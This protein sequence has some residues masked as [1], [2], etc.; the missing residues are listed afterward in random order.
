MTALPCD[1]DAARLLPW[2]VT[3]TLEAEEA[4]RVEAH[5]GSCATCRADL[6]H[7][8]RLHAALLEDAPRQGA[9]SAAAG[10]QKLM[11]RIGET[12]Q[13][14]PRRSADV[15]LRAATTSGGT[16]PRWIIAAV[17]AQALALVLVGIE[18]QRKSDGLADA[19]YRTLTSNSASSA[20]GTA[21]LRVVF[22]PGTTTRELAGILDTIGARIVD[23]PSSAGAYALAL[24]TATPDE[25]TLAAHLATLRADARVIF[26]E[27]IRAEPAR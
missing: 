4:A 13:A 22:A 24:S 16:V 3:G 11:A 17:V 15:P 7:E 5:L 18:L 27:P 26:A 2:Y 6:E 10:F 14:A 1:S 23:G 25:S 12:E 8:R 20:T 21:Q 9:S 19:P